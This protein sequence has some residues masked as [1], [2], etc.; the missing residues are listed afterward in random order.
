QAGDRMGR[1]IRDVT[2]GIN[3]AAFTGARGAENGHHQRGLTRA[4]GS[5]QRDDLALAHVEGDAPQG[6]DFAVETL[7]TAHREA[8][9]APSTRSSFPSARARPSRKITGVPSGPRPP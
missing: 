4:V 3:D 8:R 7:D 9:C 6:H 1:E 5:D 2:P